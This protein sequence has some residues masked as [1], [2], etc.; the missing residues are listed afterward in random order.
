MLPT[1]GVSFA[2]PARLDVLHQMIL[3]PR[4]TMLLELADSLVTDCPL[5]ALYKISGNPVRISRREL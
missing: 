1:R 3:M 4:V 5:A 2:A